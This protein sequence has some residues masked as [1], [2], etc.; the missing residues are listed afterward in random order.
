MSLNNQSGWYVLKAGLPKYGSSP[1][2][3]R[4]KQEKVQHMTHK[5]GPSSHSAMLESQFQVSHSIFAP[6]GYLQISSAQ[7]PISV[8]TASSVLV[9][10]LSFQVPSPQCCPT[11]LGTSV[12]QG[13][14]GG[15]GWRTWRKSKDLSQPASALGRLCPALRSEKNKA[16]SS[17]VLAPLT[18]REG[19][20]SSPKPSCSKAPPASTRPTHESFANIHQ[21]PP[22]LTELLS[23][24]TDGFTSQTAL[25]I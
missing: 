22:H 5:T 20:F 14:G 15:V 16:P 21:G 9:S 23:C 3:Y 13:G 8:G 19:V 25:S 2:I 24:P 12:H 18:P 17:V 1:M 4:N 7:M 6:M 11:V 10:N